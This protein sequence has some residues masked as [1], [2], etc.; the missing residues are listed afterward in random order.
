MNAINA[1]RIFELANGAYFQYVAQS[2]AEKAKLLKMLCSN[3]SVDGVSVTPNYRYP[4]DLIFK[5]AQRGK[6]SGRLD[7]N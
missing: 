1:K 7:S 2:N 5:S 6:W 3:F 4:F